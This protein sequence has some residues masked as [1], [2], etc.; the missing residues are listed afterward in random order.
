MTSKNTY[1]KTS[2][3]GLVAALQ[4]FGYPIETMDRSNPAKIIFVI[5]GDK[6]MDDLIQ[7]FWS[8]NLEVDALSYFESLKNIKSR[9]YQQ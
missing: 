7:K 5:A 8:K 1:F 3:L 4:I 2:D 9:I 6:M